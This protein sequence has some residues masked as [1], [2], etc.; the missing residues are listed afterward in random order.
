MQEI[1]VRGTLAG[2]TAGKDPNPS[3]RQEET[4]GQGSRRP[5]LHAGIGCRRPPRLLLMLARRAACQPLPHS[6][7]LLVVPF[8]FWSRRQG[9]MLHVRMYLV[10]GLEVL[11]VL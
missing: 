7:L 6:I 11:P 8:N 3:C 5:P 10:P 2:A 1:E 9:G 4:S